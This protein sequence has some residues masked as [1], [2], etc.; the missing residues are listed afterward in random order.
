MPWRFRLHN[1]VGKGSVARRAQVKIHLGFKMYL[2]SLLISPPQNLYGRQATRII[3]EWNGREPEFF[4]D[5]NHGVTDMPG[6]RHGDLYFPRI[7]LAILCP[8]CN[9]SQKIGGR[10]PINKN[11]SRLII[12]L[13][14]FH[15]CARRPQRPRPQVCRYTG[16]LEYPARISG[17]LA[18]FCKYAFGSAKGVEHLGSPMSMVVKREESHA[19]SGSLGRARC[20]PVGAGSLGE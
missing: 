18:S 14:D 2:Y 7:N 12:R 13:I 9:F 8:S 4:E 10:I 1:Q 19:S 5:L 16:I 17:N 11:T 6:Y 20:V 3:I 15:F